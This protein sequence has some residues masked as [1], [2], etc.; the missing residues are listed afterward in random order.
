MLDA[1]NHF[2]MTTFVITKGLPIPPRTKRGPGTSRYPFA[3]ME[4]GDCFD[5]PVPPTEPQKK[6]TT[7]LSSSVT[8]RHKRAPE[9]FT[10]R[11]IRGPSG[12]LLR[13]WRTA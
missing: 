5:V 7:R 8:Q 13:C 9:R 4:V 10:I 6:V 3:Q 1:A 11:T 12:V 2:P